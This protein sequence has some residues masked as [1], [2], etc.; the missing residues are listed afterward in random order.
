MN[1]YESFD[2]FIDEVEVAVQQKKGFALGDETFDLPDTLPAKLMLKLSRLSKS[3]EDQLKG[4]DLVLQ[5]LLGDEQ[6]ERV[7]D[8]VPEMEKLGVLAGK[9]INLYNPNNNNAGINR[10]NERSTQ[11]KRVK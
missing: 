2:A 11:R 7:L 3:N 9:I 1:E 10:P 5:T 6:Y 8:L 4:M